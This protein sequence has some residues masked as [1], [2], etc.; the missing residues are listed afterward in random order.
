MP[1]RL[2]KD[3]KIN[4]LKTKPKTIRK[5]KGLCLGGKINGRNK[6]KIIVFHNISFVELFDSCPTHTVLTKTKT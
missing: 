2:F 1:V 5:L 4:T 6:E 3:L